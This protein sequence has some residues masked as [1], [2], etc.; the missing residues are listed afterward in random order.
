MI[1]LYGLLNKCKTSQ[2]SRMLSQWLKQPLMKLEEHLNNLLD[3]HRLAKRFQRGKAT[4]QVGDD[5]HFSLKLFNS[6]DDTLRD[7]IEKIF[8]TKL[9]EHN[10]QLEKFKELV[11]TITCSS[12]RKT[13]VGYRKEL[14]FE[15]QATYEYCLRMPRLVF[16]HFIPNALFLKEFNSDFLSES[17]DYDDVQSSLVK[18]V[19]N[20]SASYCLALETLNVLLAHIDVFV[21]FADVSVHTPTPYI[22]PKMMDNDEV[23]VILKNARQ[24][25]LEIQD[26]DS[27]I[28]NDVE[29]IRGQSEL[30]IIKGPN[31]GGKSTYI[32]QIGVIALMAQVGCFAQCT[33][34]SLCIFDCILARVGAGDSQLRGVF[35]FMLETHNSEGTFKSRR[36]YAFV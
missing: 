11:E 17:E 14:H 28:P 23:H 18:E 3:L 7:L 8:L 2:G 16:H 34:A 22:R 6:M 36:A 32:K 26:D 13:R 15:K 33:E 27:F 21:T 29:L 1:S 20:I 5:S 4:L 9:K 35:T 25:C 19:I 12:W 30:Q 31:M 10:D 24:P